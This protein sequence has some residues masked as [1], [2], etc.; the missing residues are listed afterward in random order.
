MNNAYST[1][2]SGISEL[3]TRSP[4]WGIVIGV[5][6]DLGLTGVGG[7]IL[8]GVIGFMLIK[9]GVAPGELEQRINDAMPAIMSTYV[10][11]GFMVFGL[12]ASFLGGYVGARFANQKEYLIAGVL[13]L[14]SVSLT[15]YSDASYYSPL[16][17]Y[18]LM[19]VGIAVIFLGA[20]LSARRRH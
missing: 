12:F 2:E 11:Y 10:G 18:S 13:S 6:V 20:H 19:M 9:Q 4:F 3:K 17:K 16:A 1:P 8:G 14:V 7:A 5:V 15:V